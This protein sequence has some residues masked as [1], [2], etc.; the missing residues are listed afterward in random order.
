MAKEH[1]QKKI[2][3]QLF[4]VLKRQKYSFDASVENTK[5]A[6][7]AVKLSQNWVWSLGVTQLSFLGFLLLNK[8]TLEINEVWPIKMLIIFLLISF[9]SFIGASTVQF[10]YILRRVRFYESITLKATEYLQNEQYFLNNEPK[11][12]QLPTVQTTTGKITNILLL[13]SYILTVVATLG[14]IVSIILL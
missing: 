14:V 10:Q 13:I 4:D 11:E 1:K 9:I 8:D 12:L 7:E 3:K 2:K 6:N 5:I